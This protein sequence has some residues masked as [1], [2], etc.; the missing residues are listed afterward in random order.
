MKNPVVT[1]APL[2]GGECRVCGSQ[3]SDSLTCENCGAA[4]GEAN[5]CPHCRS[6]ADTEED[7]TLR[8]RCRVCGGPRVPV[9]DHDIV[10]SGRETPQLQRARR[11]QLRGA[12]WMVGAGVVGGFGLLSLAVVLLV[13]GV[14][15]PGVVATVAAIGAVAIPFVVSALAWQRARAARSEREHALDEAWSLVAADVLRHRGEELTA[16]ELG[17]LMHVSEEVAELLLANLSVR[18]VIRTRVTEEGELAYSAPPERL[19]IQDADIDL[20]ENEVEVDE[21][22]VRAK[23][24]MD[25]PKD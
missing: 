20:P 15:S 7:A 1:G 5:R 17:K 22:V 13:L 10:R 25:R 18:D 4:Y 9:D 2:P 23:A 16:A 6:V 21:S 14:A 8:H 3:L 11:A 19:R 12:G 24:Q